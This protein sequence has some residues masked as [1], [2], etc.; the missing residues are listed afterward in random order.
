MSYVRHHKHT[1]RLIAESA[2]PGFSPVEQQMVANIARYHRKAVPKPKHPA[3]G[4]LDATQQA[5]VTRLAAI[6]RMADGLDRAHEDAVEQL[7]ASATSPVHWLVEVRGDGDLAYATWGAERKA[8]L[9]E[10]TF[11]VAM[12]FEPKGAAK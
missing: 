2:L 7:D 8:G 11:D 5:I 4:E 9:F 3:F 1:L 6:L 12:R 10:D